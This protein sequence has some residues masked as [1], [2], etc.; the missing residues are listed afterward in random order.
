MLKKRKILLGLFH[1]EI[2]VVYYI[3]FTLKSASNFFPNGNILRLE[4]NI[5]LKSDDLDLTSRMYVPQ[6]IMGLCSDKS[7][8]KLKISYQKYT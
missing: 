6:F 8:I 4:E 2:I 1:K 3:S 5:R 7:I